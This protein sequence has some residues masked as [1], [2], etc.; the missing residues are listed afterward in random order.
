ME[1]GVSADAVGYDREKGA[2][3]NLSYVGNWVKIIDGKRKGEW[4][5]VVGKV[6]YLPTRGYHAVIHFED[7]VLDKR[8]I[9]DKIQ[10]KAKVVGLKLVDYP[11][12]RVM[13]SSP[14]LKISQPRP[15]F[16]L[17]LKSDAYKIVTSSS[18]P[19]PRL[20]QLS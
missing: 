1:P 6:G 7:E 10:V 18:W 2:F 12:V 16:I 5:I 14:K 20:E 19:M 15:V 13:N 11:G 9:G 4:G 8:A 17:V 3:R